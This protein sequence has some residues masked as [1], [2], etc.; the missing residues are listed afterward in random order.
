MVR[1]LLGVTIATAAVLLAGNL[2][3]NR[4]R[5][6]D[7]HHK[8]PNLFTNYYVPP[9]G[10]GGTAAQLYVS[11]RPTPPLVGHTYVTYQPLMPHEFLYPHS[12]T[13]VRRNPGSG[14]TVTKVWWD[15]DWWNLNYLL[16]PPRP[17]YPSHCRKWEP[18]GSL[19]P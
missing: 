19:W 13:Y 15:R 9:G 7:P 12:R 8:T 6:G 18:L 11:P 16:R 3:P 5:A 1:K 17:V 4:T 14:L 2:D 10:C